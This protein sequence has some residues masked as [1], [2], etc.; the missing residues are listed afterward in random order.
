MQ[1]YFNIAI[2]AVRASCSSEQVDEKKSQ[3]GFFFRLLNLVKN[4]KTQPTC[5]E[6][7]GMR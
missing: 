7:A 5:K 2:H 6:N 3:S 4:Y 1:L